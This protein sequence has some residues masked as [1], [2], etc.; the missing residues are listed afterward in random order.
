MEVN[1]ADANSGRFFQAGWRDE[2]NG[3][4]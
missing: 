4:I 3:V 1:K 2:V